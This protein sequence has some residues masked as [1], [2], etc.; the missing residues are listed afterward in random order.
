VLFL[1]PSLPQSDVGAHVHALQAWLAH[2]S[3]S[4]RNPVAGTYAWLR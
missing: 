2:A 4:G 1:S 3:A